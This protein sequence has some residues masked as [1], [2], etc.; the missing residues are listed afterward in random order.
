MTLKLSAERETV[1]TYESR[2]IAAKAGLEHRFSPTLTGAT[3]VNVEWADIDDAFG[4][5][6]YFIVSL[7]SKLDYDT[8]DNKLD[9]L[10]GLRG[11]IDA[12]PL[13]EFNA[14]TLA[15]VTKGSLAGY[16]AF[17]ESERLVLAGR[18]ALGTIVGGDTE[19]I[20]ATRRFFLGGGGSIRGYEYRSVGPEENGEV[21]GGL[22]FFEASLELRYRLTDS[23]GIVPFI[24]AGAAYEDPLPD[25]AEEISIGAGIG[26][27]YFTPLGPLRFDFAVPLTG[28][29][30]NAFAFYVGLGQAF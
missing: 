3:A 11:T 27:R 4:S 28:D 6:R 15:L 30:D 18:G 17:G 10:E 1:D 16:W 14:G 12:E 25:F 26:I 23:I 13:A 7:P 20:P 2:T 19:D 8:R 5:N 21:V 24:D 22:S 9:P 29:N